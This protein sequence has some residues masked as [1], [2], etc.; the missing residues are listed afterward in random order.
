MDSFSALFGCNHVLCIHKYIPVLK[1]KLHTAED[2]T[3]VSHNSKYFF[4]DEIGDSSHLC[5]E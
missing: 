4:A 2:F 5:R 3:F 1:C